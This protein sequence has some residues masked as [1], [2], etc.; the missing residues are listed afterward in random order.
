MLASTLKDYIST[1]VYV[2]TL[3]TQKAKISHF[4]NP[5]SSPT[6]SLNMYIFEKF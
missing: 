5:E 2:I 1:D 3:S 6:F 4:K